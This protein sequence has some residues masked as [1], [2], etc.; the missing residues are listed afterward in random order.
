MKR[1]FGYEQLYRGDAAARR[2]GALAIILSHYDRSLECAIKNSRWHKHPCLVEYIP[3]A[4]AN[5]TFLGGELLL[6]FADEFGTQPGVIVEGD[7]DWP[8]KVPSQQAWGSR[9][10]EVSKQLRKTILAAYLSTQDAV[11]A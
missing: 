9:E 7:T 2:I 11:T 1:D 4:I 3:C 6:Q 8:A 10:A 5:S